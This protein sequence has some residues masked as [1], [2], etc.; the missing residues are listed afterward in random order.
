MYFNSV[1]IGV[2]AILVALGAG[3]AFILPHMWEATGSQLPSALEKIGLVVMGVGVPG[4]F[5]AIFMDKP[6][7]MWRR[8]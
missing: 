2:S 1:M 3:C 4:Y 6:Y 7:A 8:L 5:Y